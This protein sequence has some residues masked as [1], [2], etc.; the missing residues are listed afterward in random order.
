VRWPAWAFDFQLWS[1]TNLTAPD[2]TPA[3]P[4]PATLGFELVSSNLNAAPDT[5][6]RLR[7]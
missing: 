1:G 4:P 7:R 3:G 5:F 6:F 2:W